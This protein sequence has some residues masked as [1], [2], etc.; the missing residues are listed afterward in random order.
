[1]KGDIINQK[2][3][4]SKNQKIKKSKNQKIKKSKNTNQVQL[5][6]SPT[7]TKLE[8]LMSICPLPCLKGLK[9]LKDIS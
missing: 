8:F 1:M 9:C 4:K 7:F 6:I 5:E 3:K 2:I